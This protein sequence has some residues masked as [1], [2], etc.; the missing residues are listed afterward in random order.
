MLTNFKRIFKFA[1]TDFNRNKGLSLAAVFVLIVVILLATGVFLFQGMSNYL[2]TQIQDKIDIIAYFKEDVAAEDILSVK[3]QILATSPNIK[4]IRYVSKEDALKIFTE[5]HKD[6]IVLLQALNEVGSN[7]FSPSLNIKTNG[8]PA[9]YENISNILQTSDFAKLIDSVDFS[10]KKDTIEK[11][12]SITSNINKYGLAI[13]LLFIFVA[14]LIVFNTIKLAVDTSKDEINTMRMVG[15]PDWFVRGPFI[16]Q[17]IFYGLT[18]FIISFLISV[19]L[20]YF[21]SSKIEIVL[22]G[23][24]SFNYFLNNIW[25]LILMQ[26]AFGIVLGSFTSW[27]AVRKYLK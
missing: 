4:D 15:S 8:T 21:L 13:A 9:E 17:G 6:N 16:I 1:F 20:F 27:L 22:A 2:I 7:P 10:Q 25:T 3:D 12:Y 14:I 19:I 23:F 11:V 5:K 18:A 24:N 26:F